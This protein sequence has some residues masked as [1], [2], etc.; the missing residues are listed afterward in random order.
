M[1]V[2]FDASSVS[3]SATGVTS[4]SHNHTVANQNN[5]FLIVSIWVGD[6]VTNMSVT[7]NGVAMTLAYTSDVSTHGN[8]IF[9]MFNPPVGT[10]AIAASWTTSRTYRAI[11][12]SFYNVNH[13]IMGV[14]K[15]ATLGG[16][17]NAS[18]TIASSTSEM[19]VASLR[20]DT[21]RTITALAGTNDVGTSGTRVALAY[22]QGSASET[23]G[24]SIS[25]A[26]T[27]NHFIFRLIESAP[28]LNATF[29]YAQSNEN[30]STSTTSIAHTHNLTT[31]S[32]KLL[33]VYLYVSTAISSPTV[34]FAGQSMTLYDTVLVPA[35]AN[36]RLL[37]FYLEN[38]T[39][40]SGRVVA[41]WTTGAW[42]HLASVSFFNVDSFVSAGTA[43]G[44]ST[45][46]SL[47]TTLALNEIF[48]AGMISQFDIA[49]I[50]PNSGQ[51]DLMTLSA[52]EAAL[53]YKTGVGSISIG[54]TNSLTRWAMAGWTIKSRTGSAGSVFWWN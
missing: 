31:L 50:T 18:N 46:P 5:Q 2:T 4:F 24:W 7:F 51:T 22:K 34:T 45:A 10:Y 36:T 28:P 44:S 39:L 25:G 32:D 37:R 19:L 26:T 40:N 42:C 30:T 53:A 29:N 35:G 33:L 12:G 38:P 13:Y 21:S 8:Y 3:S 43:N 15:T 54:Y 6:P 1:A 41:S 20:L 27:Y 52:R 9:V 23:I 11:A 47:T 48:L 14:E 16:I 49:T 17:G